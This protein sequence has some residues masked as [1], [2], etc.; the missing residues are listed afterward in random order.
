MGTEL[1]AARAWAWAC[2]LPAGLVTAKTFPLPC[3]GKT[4]GIV[5][6]MGGQDGASAAGSAVVATVVVAADPHRD[7]ARR[8]PEASPGETD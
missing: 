5:S 6:G 7:A 4:S 3:W 2:A 1:S 8:N